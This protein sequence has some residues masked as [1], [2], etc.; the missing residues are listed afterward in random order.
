[1]SLHRVPR[2]QLEK[3]LAVRSIQESNHRDEAVGLAASQRPCREEFPEAPLLSLRTIS[4]SRIALGSQQAARVR[5][6]CRASTIPLA[7]AYADEH[8]KNAAGLSASGLVRQEP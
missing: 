7:R 4:T 3:R 6:R 5:R 2:W 8:Q 1:M